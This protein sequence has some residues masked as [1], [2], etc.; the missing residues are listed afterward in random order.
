[1][2]GY[3]RVV[4]NGD[5]G[6]VWENRTDKPWYQLLVS[7]SNT[8]GL[9]AQYD[10]A[11]ASA[12]WPIP[13]H[14][15]CNCRQ[16]V[17]RV[18]A[19]AEPAVDFRETIRNLPPDQ[20]SACVGSANLKLIEAGV[21]AW[22]D[23]VTAHRVRDLNEV[24]AIKGL[25]VAAMT[26]V[27]VRRTIAE[28]AFA[29]VNTPAHQLVAAKRAQLLANLEGA[30]LDRDQVR[31]VLATGLASKL[32]A[33]GPS[34]DQRTKS[35]RQ[36]PEQLV[37][38]HLATWIAQRPTPPAPAPPP[39]LAVDVRGE[40]SEAFRKAIDEALALVPEDLRRALARSG[41][42]V[43]AAR[44]MADVF[45]PEE[46]DA[47]PDGWPEGSSRRNMEAIFLGKA[48]RLLI[49]E[50]YVGLASGEIK[51]SPRVAA[52]VLHEVGHGVDALFKWPSLARGFTAAYAADVAALA[53]EARAGLGY[54]LQPKHRGR[55]E[56]WAEL[57]S[58]LHG[59]RGVPEDLLDAFPTAAA[60]M[61]KFLADPRPAKKSERV[62][63]P[64]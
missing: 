28:Q 14:F 42:R 54:F 6:E 45:T 27:G 30:G 39:D 57:H 17:I 44:E 25:D 18:G 63:E 48:R 26:R 52:N 5:A 3:E 12:S 13:F 4:W 56:A 40:P 64:S 11:V 29:S 24:V 49:A 58:Q 59:R 20:R 9:C 61:R 23:V 41:V 47:R 33:T 7:W 51:A 1:M 16:V 37:R 32:S 2:A 22:S 34:G 50:R 38:L 21:V 43:V 60:W 15:G 35:S 10:R 55:Q 62:E 8:C 31:Q 36:S 53:P 19:K 46:L